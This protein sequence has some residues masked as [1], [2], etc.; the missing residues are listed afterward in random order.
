MAGP[1]GVGLVAMTTEAHTIDLNN[2]VEVPQLGFG[3]FLIR[4]EDTVEAASEALRVGYRHIDTAQMYGNE[5]QVGEAVKRSG[6]DRDQVFVTSKLSNNQRSYDDVLRSVDRSL[7][8]LGFEP[9]DLFLIH[10]PLPTV[11]DFMDA[12]RGLARVYKEGRARAIGV[13]NFQIPHLERLLSESD[14]VPVVNQIELHPY[15]AQDRLR[16]F[17]AEHGI[18]A[19]AW[20]PI[21]RGRLLD[22]PVVARLAGHAG[23]S[24]AQIIL[25]WHVQLG[26][27]IIPK[28]VHPERIKENS[29]IF[30]FSLS[31]A[32]MRELAALNRG[33]RF[34]PDPD[35]FTG[36][37]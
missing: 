15:L 4:P 9:I 10:W 1:E 2:G 32:D 37:P 14:V 20:S 16:D 7:D 21:G 34:G 29:Q 25:R 6:I 17:G 13:S 22:D 11:R 3:V 28:S 23:R 19:E 36:R 27:V 30:D 24:P 33:Q 5:Q 35:T 18:V 8:L 26:N 12:W 31:D